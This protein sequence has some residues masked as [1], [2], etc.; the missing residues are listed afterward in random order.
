MPAS[1]TRRCFTV[2]GLATVAT[3]L[4]APAARAA[5]TGQVVVPENLQTKLLSKVVAFDRNASTRA[6]DRLRVLIL[7]KKGDPESVRTVNRLKHAL[8]STASIASLPVSVQQG[9]FTGG[10]GLA[11]LVRANRVSIVY[12]TPGLGDALFMIASSLR[13]LSV[14]SVSAVPGHVADGS[15]LSFDLAEGRPKVLVHLSRARAQNVDFKASF[16][17]L[18]TIVDR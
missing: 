3:G 11:S 12:L 4:G 15:V 17:K 6:G 18:A 2:A 13:G 5:A 10:S 1:F 8:E 16:L 7:Q 9:D 14:M